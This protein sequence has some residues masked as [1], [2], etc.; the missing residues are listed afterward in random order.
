M[1]NKNSNNSQQDTK[2]RML[3]AAEKLFAH[4]GF[5][6]TSLRSITGE[7]KVNLA[8]VNYHFGTKESLLE[9]VL[10]R[11]LIPLNKVRRERMEKVRDESRQQGR[12]PLVKDLLTAFIEPTLQ[13]RESTPGADEF[14]TLVSRSFSD[15]DDTVR[16]VFMKLVSPMFKL[17]FETFHEALPE[18]PENVLL[19]RLHFMFG[20][21]SHTMHICG[22][23][24]DTDLIKFPLE[25]DTNTIITMFIPFITAGMEAL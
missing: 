18:L 15:P 17:I 1:D 4:K 16:K 10:E 25:T 23:M 8:A 20:A 9:A 12:K 6:G 14:I 7:A 3:D 24:F 21:F 13:F 2:Q 5:Q 22:G 19:W 11:R